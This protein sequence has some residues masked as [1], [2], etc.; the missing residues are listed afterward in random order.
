MC[1]DSQPFYHWVKADLQ[2]FDY[3]YAKFNTKLDP[4]TYSNDEYDSILKVPNWTKSETDQLMSVCHEYNLRWP[5]IADR[6]ET[7]C[8]RT[9]EDL[10]AR[11]YYVATQLKLHKN[12]KRTG[13][14]SNQVIPSSTFDV[15]FERCRRKQQDI[16]YKMTPE[17]HA[18]ELALRE[19]LKTLEANI[20]KMK[21]SIK[22]TPPPPPPT[23][24]TG[25]K[26]TTTGAG[27]KKK[28][29]KDQTSAL[30][31]PTAASIAAASSGGSVAASVLLKPM[32]P[33]VMYGGVMKPAPNQ[34]C[35]QSARLSFTND[36]PDFSKKTVTG[37]EGTSNLDLSEPFIAKLKH[38]SQEVGMPD[39][40][41]PTRAVCDL[42]DQVH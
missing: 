11:Y 16:L 32:P 26:S 4:I 18:E 14:F 39:R 10:M 15:E 31:A 36:L 40:L 27:S 6:F 21:K 37:F 23:V 1:S 22:Q 34:P 9:T 30:S 35:L 12:E 5:V 7:T 3:V 25:T 29:A 2:N 33:I 38:Y 13:N 42:H 41:L 28:N 19:E 8:H 17:D 24:A 20:K